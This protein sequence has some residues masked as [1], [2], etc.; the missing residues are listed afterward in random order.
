LNAKSSPIQAQANA[1][2]AV[3]IGALAAQTAMAQ[4]QLALQDK[5]ATLAAA[6]ANASV[7]EAV[8]TL[9]ANTSLVNSKA[10]NINAQ[11]A[12]AKAEKR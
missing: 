4:Q 2:Q 8:K 9:Q 6:Q 11:V 10:T 7:A 12:L 1:Q 5:L 3:E